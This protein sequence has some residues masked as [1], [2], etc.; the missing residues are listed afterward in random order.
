MSVD[1]VNQALT[2]VR[3]RIS[4]D[5]SNSFSIESKQR[6][7]A[8]C[9]VLRDWLMINNPNTAV[10]IADF[11]LVVNNYLR[12][13]PDA[14]DYLLDEL[15]AELGFPEGVREQLDAALDAP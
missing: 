13:Q 11:N 9:N 6:L 4:A 10:V 5:Q 7:L 3:L 2:A 15:F 14:A 12:N 8:M 1:T